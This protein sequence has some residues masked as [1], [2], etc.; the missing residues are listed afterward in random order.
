MYAAPCRG[1]TRGDN[2]IPTGKPVGYDTSPLPGLYS[3]TITAAITIAISV[4][5]PI[6]TK[7]V[8]G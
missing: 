6:P 4:P 8:I 1:G 2:W 7:A 5:V 3:I